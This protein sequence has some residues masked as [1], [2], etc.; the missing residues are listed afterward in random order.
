MKKSLFKDDTGETWT[1]E[2]ITLCND[3]K[4]VLAPIIAK[5]MADG[6]KMRD[7]AYVVQSEVELLVSG[8]LVTAVISKIKK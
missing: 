5:A 3:V 7:V 4:N 1:P 6:Y 2:A 8:E